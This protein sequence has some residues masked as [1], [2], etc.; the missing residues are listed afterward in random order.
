MKGKILFVI[1]VVFVLWL[2]TSSFWDPGIT[3]DI[4]NIPAM[5]TE[6]FTEVEI[7]V[8]GGSIKLIGDCYMLSMIAND[9]QIYSISQGMSGVMDV[10]PT[11]HDTVK[12]MVDMFGIEVLMVKVHS[13]I[14]GT[15]YANLF[16]MQ[17]NKVL[18]L[19]TRPSD[20]IGIAVRTGSPVYVL[21]SL[22]RENGVYVC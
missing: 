11:S 6:G 19:D 21:D 20:A 15:Y 14:E 3:G 17:G 7:G 8:E 1:F 13:L 18:N 5:S 4:V 2:F 16:M 22:L 10:R 9:Y 12:N